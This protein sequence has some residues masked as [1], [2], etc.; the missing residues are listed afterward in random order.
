MK[1]ILAQET[2]TDK[3]VI[4]YLDE[5]CSE[6]EALKSRIA[7]LDDPNTKAAL[8]DAN[9][10]LTDCATISEKIG[11]GIAL[12]TKEKASLKGLLLAT[13]QNIERGIVEGVSTGIDKY[14]SQLE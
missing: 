13:K 9:S 6:M 1:N 14:V 8:E 10:L 11:K 2:I 4:T 7:N 5:I 3:E 12:T